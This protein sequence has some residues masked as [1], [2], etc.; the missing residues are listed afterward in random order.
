M[1]PSTLSRRAFLG[2]GAALGMGARV[3]RAC[4]FDEANDPPTTKITAIDAI[5]LS[6]P[7][8]PFEDGVDKTG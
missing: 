3:A 8:S 2:S 7:V 5:P 1:K 4:G 6:L